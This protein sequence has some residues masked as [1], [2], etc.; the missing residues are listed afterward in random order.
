MGKGA[1]SA[2][3]I[4]HTVGSKVW[5]ADP[6]D[7]WAKGEVIE[8]S[9]PDQLKVRLEDGKEKVCSQ[10]EIPLQNPG[11]YGVEVSHSVGI[12]TFV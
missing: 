7:G 4:L 10:D 5:L 1:M 11:K 6:E 9:S 8:A 3:A 2:E 12:G